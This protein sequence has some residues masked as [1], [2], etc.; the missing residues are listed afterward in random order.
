MQDEFKDWQ[1]LWQDQPTSPKD[2]KIMIQQ[3]NKIERKNRLERIVLVLS[4]P[5]TIALLLSVLPV[6]SSPYYLAAI[7]LISVAMLMI[8][9]QSYRMRFAPLSEDQQFDNRQFLETQIQKLKIKIKL[10]STYMWI[11]AILLI[12][13]INI[14]Y[15]EALAPMSPMM[16]IGLHLFVTVTMLLGMYFG[17]R[18]RL[19]KYQT[20]LIPLVQ[21]LELIKEEL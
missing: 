5:L 7:V 13:G 21:Q 10:T 17:I 11:Y 14:G 16:R 6:L 9:W 19:K 15:L 4:F 8:I 12:S 18:H 2:L 3:L 1:Q 20:D